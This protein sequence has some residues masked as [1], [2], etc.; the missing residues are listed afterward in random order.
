MNKKFTLSPIGLGLSRD[1]FSSNL[2]PSEPKIK[3]LTYSSPSGL[4][5]NDYLELYYVLDGHG[6]FLIN[7]VSYPCRNGNLFMRFNHHLTRIIPAKGQHLTLYRCRFTLNTYFYFLA[8]PC[9]TQ[10]NIGL[11][12]HPVFLTLP[13]EEKDYIEHLF[14]EMKELSAKKSFGLE[15][16]QILDL[17][18]IIIRMERILYKEQG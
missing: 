3:E 1:Y 12:N 9:C 8:N 11:S 2:I 10:F 13:P 15:T 18:E 5:H 14:K 17:L 7:G 16:M 6:T 4:I